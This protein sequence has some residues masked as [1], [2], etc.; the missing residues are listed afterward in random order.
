MKPFHISYAYGS[1]RIAAAAWLLALPMVASAADSRPQAAAS[2]VSS[3][4]ILDGSVLLTQGQLEVI[5]LHAYENW[6]RL[7]PIS[8]TGEPEITRASNDTASV[9]L[10]RLRA[11]AQPI[12]ERLIQVG[13][14]EGYPWDGNPRWADS[15]ALATVGHAREVFGF[16]SD[17]DNDAGLNAYVKAPTDGAKSTVA[18]ARSASLQGKSDSAL[19]APVVGPTREG[20]VRGAQSA[21]SGRPVRP[22]KIT[23]DYPAPGEKL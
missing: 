3:W 6:N 4:V 5:A 21:E 19:K 1:S 23:I 2:P 11:V 9:T 13:L 18:Q 22:L 16:L 10:G 14:A 8:T 17:I 7:F 15:Q 12:Y 20:L